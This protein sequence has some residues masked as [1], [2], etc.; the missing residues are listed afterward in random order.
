MCEWESSFQRCVLNT[1][2]PNFLGALSWL[3]WASRCVSAARVCVPKRGNSP[4]DMQVL[5][6]E[7][8]KQHA[9]ND[10]RTRRLAA[11][12]VQHDALSLYLHQ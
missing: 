10:A 5:A 11:L 2:I 8:K 6:H 9:V 1:S 3:G 4:N 12:Q 7:R